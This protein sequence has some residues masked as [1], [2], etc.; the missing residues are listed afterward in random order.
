MFEH[1][2]HTRCTDT[3][4]HFNEIRTRDSKE[5]HFSFTSNRFGKQGFTCTRRTNHEYTRWDLTT[6]LLEAARIA[7]V[8]DQFF[9]I[10]FCFIT[11]R[12]V[13]ESGFYLVFTHH[14]RFALT[15]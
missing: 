2:T 10:F 5:W 1:V 9:H 14:T 7:Q 11:A 6:Q 4:K 13:A 3:D 8:I 15:K 12:N